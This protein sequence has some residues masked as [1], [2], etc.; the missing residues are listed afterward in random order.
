[1][2]NKPFKS[3]LPVISQGGG[4]PSETEN[5]RGAFSTICS[6]VLDTLKEQRIFL[7]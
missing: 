4:L 2:G 5:W 3:L 1:M 7:R 6:L